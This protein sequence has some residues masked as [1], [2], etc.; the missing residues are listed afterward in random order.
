MVIGDWP[1]IVENRDIH[2]IGF[3]DIFDTKKE[4]LKVEPHIVD[5]QGPPSVCLARY[6]LSG[7]IH[8][9]GSYLETT[10]SMLDS[11][12]SFCFYTILMLKW[13]EIISRSYPGRQIL[14]MAWWLDGVTPLWPGQPTMETRLQV[15]KGSKGTFSPK[16][17]GLDKERFFSR[18]FRKPWFLRKKSM[19]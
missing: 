8:R 11:V 1:A 19:N 7:S 9:I 3:H 17:Y 10:K 18:F 2:V 15:M 13:D 6:R 5:A 16:K 4:D 12:F 14:S